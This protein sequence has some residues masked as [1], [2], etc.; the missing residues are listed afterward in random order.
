MLSDVYLVAG[1]VRN[2]DRKRAIAAMRKRKQDAITNA[3]TSEAG[4]QQLELEEGA[5]AGKKDRAAGAAGLAFGRMS[6]S[7]L[8]NLLD[9]IQARRTRGEKDSAGRRCQPPPSRARPR[10]RAYASVHVLLTL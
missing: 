3:A 9:N 10:S 7:M 8:M 2:F 1:P 4:M 6:K 5:E